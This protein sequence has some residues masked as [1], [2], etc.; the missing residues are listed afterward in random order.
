MADFI[1]ALVVVIGFLVVFMP[2]GLL[3]YR[4]GFWVYDRIEEAFEK[5]KEKR[6][7]NG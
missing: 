4:Y 5:A 2:I 7:R 1:I 3:L 6:G